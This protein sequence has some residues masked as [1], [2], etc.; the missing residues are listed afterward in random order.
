M[1]IVTNKTERPS[2]MKIDTAPLDEIRMPTDEDDVYLDF[3]QPPKPEWWGYL[4][5]HNIKKI[6][7]PYQ[8]NAF[9][10]GVLHDV[11]NQRL[12]FF[13]P[14]G[15]WAKFNEAFAYYWNEEA[16]LNGVISDDYM[17]LSI[18]KQLIDN[19]VFF[20]DELLSKTV[21]AIYDF[22]M[23]IPGVILDY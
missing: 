2:I 19:M 16:G 22:L 23:E 10:E 8:E 3:Y 11:A 18:R 13:I 7:S 5:N 4:G 14:Y 20:P 1:S 6:I 15:I 12:G 17:F 9:S 21:S